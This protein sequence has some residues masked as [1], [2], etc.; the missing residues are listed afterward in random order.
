MRVAFAVLLLLIGTALGAAAGYGFAQ[1]G[2]AATTTSPGPIDIGFAQAMRNHHDQ[3][4]VLTDILLTDPASALSALA[5]DIQSAQLLEIGQMKAWLD[6]W[7]QP[8]LPATDSME[9]MLLGTEPPGKAL[10]EYLMAC[11]N[12]P[13]GMPGLATR[14]EL[15]RLRDLRGDERDRLFLQLMV[16]HHQGG[17]PMLRFAADHAQVAAVRALAARMTA[18]QTREL[19][20]MA[21]L[22]GRSR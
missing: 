3:A 6:L 22:A 18:E 15:A 7:G 8:L 12:A 2:D 5:R 17:L 16:R 1:R 10:L 9:W 11:R 13:G 4:V 20:A 14:D 21:L 19:A